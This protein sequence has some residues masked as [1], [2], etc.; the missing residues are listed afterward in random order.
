MPAFCLLCRSKTNAELQA[1][2][3]EYAEKFDRDLIKDLKS[4]CSGSFEDVL[5]GLVEE[6]AAYDAQLCKRA[7]KGLGTNEDLLVPQCLLHRFSRV[8]LSSRCCFPPPSPKSCVL[9]QA[10]NWL[11][12]EQLTKLFTEMMYDELL[13]LLSSSFA[14]AVA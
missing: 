10:R 5:V 12:P 14:I 9:E 6:T 7:M 4:E 1:T 13:I 3:K 2:R 8:K 11:P